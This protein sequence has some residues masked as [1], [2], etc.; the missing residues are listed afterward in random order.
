MMDISE[1]KRNL[2][3]RVTYS[4]ESMFLVDAEYTLAGCM[5][6]KSIDGYYYTAEL[7][8][9]CQPRSVIHVPLEEVK[10]CGKPR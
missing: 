1:V 2:N 9:V 3:R 5:L 8:S 7:L 4:N 6:R 10:A